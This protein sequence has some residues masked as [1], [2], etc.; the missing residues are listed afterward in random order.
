M[1]ADREKLRRLDEFDFNQHGCSRMIKSWIWV[2][3]HPPTGAPNIEVGKTASRAYL[4][5]GLTEGARGGVNAVVARGVGMTCTERHTPVVQIEDSAKIA[6]SAEVLIYPQ[7]C[8]LTVSSSS[9]RIYPDFQVARLT[10]N[11]DMAPNCQSKCGKTYTK[12]PWTTGVSNQLLY[13]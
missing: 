11:C 7:P 5:G 12:A 10:Q 1:K 8:P 4:D 2:R 13:E 3:H 9:R 6:D